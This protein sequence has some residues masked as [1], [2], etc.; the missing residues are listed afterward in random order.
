MSH[1]ER[2]VLITRPFI[3]TRFPSSCRWG[4]TAVADTF[5]GSQGTKWAERDEGV[6]KPM[7]ASTK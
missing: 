3:I 2:M 4:G 5:F 1:E 7:G 6:R